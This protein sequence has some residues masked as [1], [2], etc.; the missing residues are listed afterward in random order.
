MNLLS[1]SDF[2]EKILDYYSMK[3]EVKKDIRIGPMVP[4]WVYQIV[5]GIFTVASI[6]IS[7]IYFYFNFISNKKI[8][9]EILFLYFYIISK[10]ILLFL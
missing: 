7:L 6:V 8:L 4:E 10:T 1:E 9:Y 3:K 2:E 5:G